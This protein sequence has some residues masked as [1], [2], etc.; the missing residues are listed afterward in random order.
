[1][2]HATRHQRQR[3]GLHAQRH[4]TMVATLPVARAAHN[5]IIADN[6][7]HMNTAIRHHIDIHIYT[8]IYTYI[9]IYKLTKKAAKVTDMPLN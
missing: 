5:A 8:Y 4:T 7:A 9:Y 1:M 2:S 3:L 6:P